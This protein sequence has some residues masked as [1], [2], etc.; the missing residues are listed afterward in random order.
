MPNVGNLQN[1]DLLADGYVECPDSYDD[2]LHV[3]FNH[4]C[5]NTSCECTGFSVA[6]Q[7]R[8]PEL[9]FLSNWKF[10]KTLDITG[11]KDNVS[12]LFKLVNALENL[13]LISLTHNDLL[14]LSNDSFK[15]L[16]YITVIDLSNNKLTV[17]EDGTFSNVKNLSS[18]DLSF[19]QLQEITTDL[20]QG[21][22]RII[23][24]NI[25]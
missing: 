12:H 24:L 13:I 25:A 8:L 18:L 5:R 19:N 10:A 2:E 4:Y 6:C 1:G 20:L 14:C 9:T 22:S 17:I 21:L 3:F 7:A 11:A 23:E 15:S 16:L